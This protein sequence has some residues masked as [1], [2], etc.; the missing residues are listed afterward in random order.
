[1]QLKEK[2]K[3]Q[4]EPMR[5]TVRSLIKNHGD[6]VISEVTVRQALGGIRGVKCLVCDTSNLDPMEG[7]R[8]RG[9]TIPEVIEKLPK[10]PGGE[11]PLPEGIF[12]LLMT[13]ELPTDNEVK[14]DNYYRQERCY[15]KFERCFT[16]PVEIDPEKI[17][18]DYKDGVL[19]IDIPKAEESKPKQVT[20]H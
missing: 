10:A 3:T 14:E 1:M 17:K 9:Y 18:A 19:K 12:H 11:Q 13:G 2:L 15:G 7:I 5:E 4:I 20:I 16:L 8:F 6:K